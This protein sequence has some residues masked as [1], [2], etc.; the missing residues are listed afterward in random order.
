MSKLWFIGLPMVVL[1]SAAP[2]NPFPSHDLPIRLAGSLLV[3]GAEGVGALL[4]II[5]CA[6]LIIGIC[7]IG[8]RYNQ[9]GIKVAALIFFKPYVNV[10]AAILIFAAAHRL[11]K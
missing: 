8:R 5:G 7:H 11:K 4:T 1:A 6:G 10:A 9:T 2:G 3:L